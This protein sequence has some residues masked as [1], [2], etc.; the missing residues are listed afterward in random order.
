MFRQTGHELQGIAYTGS[1]Y[2]SAHK[3]IGRVTLTTKIIILFRYDQ[4]TGIEFI[5]VINEKIIQKE[6]IE[7]KPIP[8]A[9]NYNYL[10][11]T[12][13]GHTPYPFQ[14][15]LATSESLP[16]LMEIPTG[17]GKTDSI[18]L[19]WLWRRRFDPRNEI[20]SAT[21]RRLIYCLPMRVLVEQ[22]KGKVET[23]LKNLGVFGEYP[24]DDTPPSGFAEEHDPN[25]KR[26]AVTVLMGGEEREWWDIYPDRDAIIIGTQDMLLSRALNRGYGMSRY[27][28]PM[29]FGLLNNDC[30]WVMDEVQLMGRGL[31]TTTQL[32]AFRM[33]LG[34]IDALPARTIWMSATL[35]RDWLSTV[36]FDPSL[37]ISNVLTLS[38]NDH[39]E[40]SIQARTHALKTLRRARS[41]ATDPKKLADII[42]EKHLTDTRTLVVVNTVKRAT[43]LYD[44]ILKKKLDVR[45][46]LIHSRYRLP[47]RRRVVQSLLDKP[48]TEGTII[49]STQ[50]VE[51]GVD[52]SARILFTELAPWPSLVQRF[53]RCNRSGE[54][55]DAEVYWIDIPTE[56]RGSALPYT[57]EELFQARETLINL[58]EKSVGPAYLP[59]VSRKYIHKQVIRQ[60]DLIDLFDT[61]P[62][63]TGSDIDISRF[64]RDSDDMDV[65]V[66][67]R[68][69]PEVSQS[70]VNNEVLPHR[71]ELCSVPITD[72]RDLIKKDTYAWIWNSL[73]GEWIRV[74]KNLRIYPGMI[75]ML[76]SQDGRYTDSRG[77]DP[78][79]KRHVTVISSVPDMVETGYSGNEMAVGGWLSVAEHTDQVYEEMESILD[80]IGLDGGLRES[81]LEGARWH[82]AGKA[83]RAFQTLIKE[84]EMRNCAKLPVAKAPKYAWKGRSGARDCEENG[85]RRYFRHELA[86]GMLALKNGRD[87]LVAYLAA[88]HHG[89]VRASIRSMPDECFPQDRNR[90]FARG[91]WEGDR[92]PETDLGGG[93]TLPGAAIDLSFMDIGVN[94][95]GPSWSA[96]VLTL[97]DDPAIGPFRLAYLEALLKASDERASRGGA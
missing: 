18:V 91:V 61:T 42:I 5:M 30:L 47:D 12:A 37:T 14:H 19:G 11:K 31:A 67:W 86:S 57:D 8:T 97:R 7:R 22:T 64:I 80:V 13:T 3:L 39:Q 87:D 25:G 15:N 89:K 75:L 33:R 21:P 10:F 93:V 74:R 68:D 43:E 44:T 46:V 27:R 90:R 1:C 76:R 60:K 41:N 59:Q 51:A 83:H 79:S 69:I 72:I 55:H 96:R 23:W 16:D 66:F 73:D 49:I 85:R 4:W 63:L 94:A 50:V 82:D 65:Q 88:S 35:E 40:P 77:W 56:K 29:H 26:I 70:E 20:L 2:L 9:I 54:Y 78:K 36:D 52:V 62:D 53:G 34:T 32:H 24:G 84:D 38:S 28:W 45:L 95:N 81:L 17:M 92:I 48:G 58:E 6:N 71:D